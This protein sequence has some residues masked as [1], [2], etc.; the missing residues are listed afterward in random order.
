LKGSEKVHIGGSGF[1]FDK[2]P[3]LPEEIEHHMPDYHLYDKWIQRE[4]DRAEEEARK[5]ERKFDKAAFS[6]QFKEYTEYSIGFLTRGCFRKC[7]FCINQKYDRVFLHSPL[8][9]FFDP[10]RKKI[11]LLDDNFLGCSQWKEVLQVL[12]LVQFPSFGCPS[13]INITFYDE[14][15]FTSVDNAFKYSY[16]FSKPAC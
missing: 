16:A 14:D 12:T 10:Q 5:K 13:L 15:S 3:N 2:A 4:V 7:P 1:Y 11:C 9:E 8:G 6:A